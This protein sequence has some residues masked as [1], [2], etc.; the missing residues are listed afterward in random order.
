MDRSS[1]AVAGTVDVV[2]A[3][4]VAVAVVV[5]GSSIAFGTNQAPYTVHRDRFIL[6]SNAQWLELKPQDQIVFIAAGWTPHNYIILVWCA[7]IKGKARR[8]QLWFSGCCTWYN[9]T[10]VANVP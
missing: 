5:V 10:Q 9:Y 2:V 7:C 3:V 4:A 8:L 1:V 6:A